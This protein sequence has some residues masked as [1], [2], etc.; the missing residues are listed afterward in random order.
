MVAAT[1]CRLHP[2]VPISFT[3]LAAHVVVGDDVSRPVPDEAAALAHSHAVDVQRV[4][5]LRYG[6]VHGM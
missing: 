4:E 2:A 3:P 1:L 5:V 6:T